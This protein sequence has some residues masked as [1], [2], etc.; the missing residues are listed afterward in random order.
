M[1]SSQLERGERMADT[2]ITMKEGTLTYP[3]M[4]VKVE[5]GTREDGTKYEVHQHYAPP[6]FL[7][8]VTDSK[9]RNAET[10][11]NEMQTQ[12]DGATTEIEQTVNDVVTQRAR[13]D[14]ATKD[15]I[16]NG[17]LLKNGG[18][19]LNTNGLSEYSG[20]R[21]SVDKWILHNG[22][23]LMVL[24]KGIRLASDGDETNFW[25]I[26]QDIENWSDYIGK[27]VTYSVKYANYSGESARI[28]IY[29]GVS[30]SATLLTDGNGIATITH[31]VKDNAT[32]LAIMVTK[33][34]GDTLNIDVIHAKLELGSIATEYV[35]PDIEMEKVRCGLGAT[36]AELDNYLPLTGGTLTNRLTISPL[37]GNPEIFLQNNVT[38]TVG[39]LHNNAA[40][41]IN[42]FNMENGSTA[43]YTALVLSGKDEELA[44]LLRLTRTVNGVQLIYK[45]FG[46]H[47]S[48]AVALSS[49]APTNTTALWYNPTT[50]A[51]KSYVDGAWQ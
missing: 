22:T 48:N 7:S 41:Q 11:L 44:K 18:Y 17:N 36:K 33:E 15:E 2:E 25:M 21:E 6:T 31:T 29:D 30:E 13:E 10:R 28:N 27:T 3:P 12:I 46:E 34:L 14:I 19:K 47:N 8:Q 32:R 40:K 37:T 5:S 43:N 1:D 50:K 39:T 20:D 35:E 4:S 9:G 38:G 49:T 45:V 24:E 16:I 42:I 51:L 26:H 23:T